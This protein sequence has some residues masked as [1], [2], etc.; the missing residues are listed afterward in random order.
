MDI[1]IHAN[2]AL[3]HQ[4]EYAEYFRAGF[5]RHGLKAEI[6]GSKEQ[7]A[8]IHVIQ[9]PHFCKDVWLGH[10]NV[11]LLDREY[12]HGEFTLHPRN[13]DWVSVGW[14][15]KDGGR[16][17]TNTGGREPPIV[18]SNAAN[19]GAIFLR[20][21]GGPSERADAIR[22]HPAEKRSSIGLIE[23]LHGYR[24]AIGYQTSALVTAGLEGLEVDCR[25]PRNIMWES[26]WLDLLPYA[27]WHYTEIQSGE[28][29]ENLWQSKFQ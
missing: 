6:T 17:F 19:R 1:A 11:I 29:I 27:D 3:P 25:D 21:F 9:G 8:D 26:N 15:R 10:P 28:L 16:K 24:T 18:K 2:L 14:M 13:M 23:E 12:Y 20:D 4:R 5:S 22:Y 7:N